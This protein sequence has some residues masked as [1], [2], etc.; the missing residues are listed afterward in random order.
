MTRWL[1]PLLGTVAGAI[2]PLWFSETPVGSILWSFTVIAAAYG[3][4]GIVDRLTGRAAPSA[5]TIVTGLAALLVIST[6]CARLGVLDRAIQLAAVI[7]GLVLCTLVRS[8]ISALRSAQASMPLW[9]LGFVA[10]LWLVA[11]VAMDPSTPIADG[12]NHVFVVKRLWDTG[13]LAPVHHQVGI[14]LVGASYFALVG[15]ASAAGVFEAGVCAALVVYVLATELLTR[16]APVRH[17]VFCVAVLAIVL[18]QYDATPEAQWSGA[19]FHVAAFVAL[20]SAIDTSRRGWHAAIIAVALAGLRHEYALL[21]VPYV[22]AALV[23]PARERMPYKYIA[24]ALAGY[25]AFAVGLQVALAVALPR[26]LVNAGLLILAVPL[27]GIVLALAGGLRW[28]SAVGTL[29]F[30]VTTFGLAVLLDAIRPAQHSAGATFAVWLGAVVCISAAGNTDSSASGE[31]F[32][33]GVWF[34]SFAAVILALTWV[35]APTRDVVRRDA[36][37]GRF[38]SATYTLKQEMLLGHDVS[39]H[40]RMARLQL[41]APAG[42][43]IGFWGQSA[44]F[45][46]HARNPIRDVSWP[47]HTKSRRNDVYLSPLTATSLAKLDYVLLEGVRANRVD[48]PWRRQRSAIPPSVESLLE[49]VA[50]DGTGFLYRVRR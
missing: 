43:R 17:V 9:S 22:A 4:G 41:R 8:P 25:L 19:L 7:T 27:T 24:L 15:G 37:L 10:A 33:V 26:A 40:D 46:D 28:R 44:A 2:A 1:I 11:T 6:A 47:A 50:T 48:D 45:L 21:A 12:A 30:A 42:A 38:R 23:L 20:R 31:R 13:S 3:Y 49:P 39:A 18:H 14:Q 36:V 34:A 29:V 32:A 5:L 35:V 16:D